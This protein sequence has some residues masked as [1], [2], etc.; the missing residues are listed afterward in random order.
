MSNAGIRIELLL[1]KESWSKARK[2]IRRELAKRPK[3][4]W[5][6]TRLSSTYYEERRYKTALKYVKKA[7]KIAPKC[8]LVIWDYACTL[9]MI[10]HHKNA[11]ALFKMLISR[12]ERSIAFDECGEGIRWA[13]SLLNDC[14]YWIGIS[15]RSLGDERQAR[16]FIRMH[17]RRRKSGLPSLYNARSIRKK[18]PEL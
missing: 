8:P 18:F 9:G 6:L 4:H 12:G 5:L 14:R 7:R 17:L 16:S 11:I 13:K 15:Y 1:Q 3:S 10:G 2:V